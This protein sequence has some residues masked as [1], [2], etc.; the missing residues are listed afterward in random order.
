MNYE[1][2]LRTSGLKNYLALLAIL[3]LTTGLNEVI[4]QSTQN[5]IFE[6]LSN[7][8]S[9]E[10]IVVVHQ[11]EAVKRLVGTRI[12]NENVNSLNGKMYISTRGYR[13]QVYSGNIQRTSKDEAT[14]LQVKIKGLYP[15]LE[16]DIK[17]IAP[18]WK[19]FV[20]NFLTYE[21]AWTMC[22]E[23][24]NVYPQKKNEIYI[25]EDDI[26]LPMDNL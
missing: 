11:S 15:N 3:F 14:S 5:S 25:I 7:P 19:L 13:I 18:F 2:F 4:A 17:F 6:S 8:K 26:L 16:S 12:V 20:G 9:G 10:G 21:E 24:R 23:L 22:R 1:F